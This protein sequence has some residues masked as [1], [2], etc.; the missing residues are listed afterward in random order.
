MDVDTLENS[1]RL[2]LPEDTLTKVSKK[3]AWEYCIYVNDNDY[4]FYDQNNSKISKPF[5]MLVVK[6][7]G[8]SGIIKVK[9]SKSLI[10]NPDAI[11]YTIT[12]FAPSQPPNLDTLFQGGSSACDIFPGTKETFGGEINGYGESTPLGDGITSN[13]TI[14]YLYN[15]I[16]PIVEYAPNGSILA[17]YIYA[18]GLHIAK[19][20]GADTHWYH[21][22]ALGS[23]RKMT[24]ERGSTVWS[25]TYYPFGEMTAGS[26]NTHGFTGKEFD[27]EMGLNYFCQRYYD[28]EIGRFTTLDTWS[29]LPDDERLLSYEK[30]M[31][32][33]NYMS[34]YSPQEPIN[35]EDYRTKLKKQRLVYN[36]LQNAVISLYSGVNIPMHRYI[37]YNHQLNCYLYCLNNPLCYVDPLGRNQHAVARW[38]SCVGGGAL[39]GYY[40]GLLGAGVGGLAGP[41]GAIAGGFIGGGVGGYYG[42]QWGGQAFDWL[43]NFP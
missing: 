27:S 29:N 1:G 18:G 36:N 43:T 26:N 35:I 40:G 17:R 13:Y 25:A 11:R 41:F 15:G 24:D 7:P 16:N 4:G 5:G 34:K 14:Y 30:Y 3:C 42:S 22:D 9:I 2:T 39:G 31:S 38:I 12:T 23:P 6:T 20:A 33:D 10:N 32:W 21:C 37:A 8:P 28:P 19:V